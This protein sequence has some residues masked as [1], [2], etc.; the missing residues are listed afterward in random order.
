M[1]PISKSKEGDTTTG[2]IDDDHEASD[3]EEV[4][5]TEANWNSKVK[6]L[7]MKYCGECHTEA[8]G[9]NI[10][11]KTSDSF[12]GWKQTASKIAAKLQAE[13]MPPPDAT[14]SPKISASERAKL[15]QFAQSA[16]R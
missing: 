15:K 5:Y 8:A 13:T 3:E 7:A 10:P 4:T 1:R 2:E 12:E 14:A 11:W 6:T 16:T 9:K